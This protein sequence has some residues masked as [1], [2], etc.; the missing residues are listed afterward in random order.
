MFL[1]GDLPL[2]S[3]ASTPT[4]E[5]VPAN[6]I[7]QTV[8]LGEWNVLE[9]KVNVNGL[10]VCIN[11]LIVY[12]NGL[13]V[14][15]NGLMVY[16]NGFMLCIYGLIVYLNGLMVYINGLI[17]VFIN[18]IISDRSFPLYQVWVDVDRSIVYFEGNKSSCLDR[19][20]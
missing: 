13:V 15:V 1:Q 17:D 9:S 2:P 12:V 7:A 20:L 5:A 14:Y 3:P 16:L 10:M 11:G 19:H 6:L 8:T 4:A 18:S